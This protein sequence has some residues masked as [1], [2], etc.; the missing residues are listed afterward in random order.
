ML[1][2]HM[3]KKVD[4]SFIRH[5][6]LRSL[7]MIWCKCKHFYGDKKPRWIVPLEVI[8]QTA[9]YT[10]NMILR[11]DDLTN[12]LNGKVLLKDELILK[13]RLGW[14]YFFQV[15]NLYIQDMRSGGIF[16]QYTEL[17]KIMMGGGGNQTN[18]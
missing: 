12:V 2:Q 14:W 3:I 7:F 10:E 9:E 4:N 8:K 5:V 11:Y 15:R 13:E 16:D 6:I 1:I 18:F 17:D